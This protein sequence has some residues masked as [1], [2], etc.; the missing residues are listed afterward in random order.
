MPYVHRPLRPNQRPNRNLPLLRLNQKLLFLSRSQM[1]PPATVWLYRTKSSTD[2]ILNPTIYSRDRALAKL[3]K[4]RFFALS[5][6]AGTTFYFSWTD[7]PKRGE[8]GSI[9]VT[10]GQHIFIEVRW[11]Q[12]K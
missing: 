10:S 11:H 8:E 5:V 3:E 9:T 4:G 7:K 1:P 12:M 6:P 2:S